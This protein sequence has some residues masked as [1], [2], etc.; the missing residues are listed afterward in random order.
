MHFRQMLCVGLLGC[1]LLAGCTAMLDS[2]D[3]RFD[4]DAGGGVTET[5]SPAEAEP[6][7]ETA[8]DAPT[9]A[10]APSAP[11]RDA[12]MPAPDDAATKPEPPPEEVEP[13]DPV[14][15]HPPWRWPPFGALHPALIHVVIS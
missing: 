6:G 1:L 5:Q 15:T 10:D 11:T 4:S 12:G 7:S 14:R 8:S 2:Q 9:D 3:V 13:D